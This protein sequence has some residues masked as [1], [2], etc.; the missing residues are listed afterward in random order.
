MAHNLKL[1]NSLGLRKETMDDYVQVENLTREAFWN[2]HVPG[3]NEHYLVKVLR[4]S[5]DF[6]PELDYVAELDGALAGN[7]MYAKSI[8]KN[9]DGDIYQVLTFGPVSVLP[10]YKFMGIGSALIKHTLV[11]AKEL[12]YKAVLIYGDPEYYQRFGFV[13]A[14]EFGI[15][16]RYGLFSPALQVLELE[17]GHLQG[18][19]GVF[20]EADVYELD[21]AAAEAFE[22]TFPPKLK[23]ETA[24]QLRFRELLSQSHE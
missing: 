14:E 16:G 20:Y 7:I 21:E 1:M 4:D 23:T 18:V 8:V 3:C 11:L 9:E 24:S 5:E 6:L 19:S 2:V 17:S 15:K 12:G 22:A 10:K 13:A